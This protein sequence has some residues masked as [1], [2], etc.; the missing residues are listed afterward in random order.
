MGVPPIRVMRGA[1]IVAARATERGRM[2]R[3]RDATGVRALL[4]LGA[5][6]AVG[7][8]AVLTTQATFADQVS[9]AQVSVTGGTLDLTAN[10]GNGP[11]ATWTGTISAAVTN[12]APGDEAS[13][14]MVLRNNGTLPLSATVSKTGG[15]PAGCFSYW[16]RE[17]SAT[18]ATKAAS[19]PVNLAG[20][21]TAAGSDGTT[22]AFAPAVSS[23]SLPDVGADAIWET[24]DAKTY[25]LTVR[26]RT[27]CTTN[28]AAGTL[29]F[30]F[31][32]I[33]V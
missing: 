24:D 14:T 31:N 23:V 4:S 17:T 22:A 20:M 6:A 8:L 5:L 11:G 25:T 12:M 28:G 2:A 9:M 13:G 10:G 32:A 3:L 30:T 26:M 19:W 7:S 27:A 16:L 33:Q 29:D 21:G 1:T 15:D 18:G